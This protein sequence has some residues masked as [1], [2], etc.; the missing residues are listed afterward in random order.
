[1]ETFC[2]DCRF[3]NTTEC[4]IKLMCNTFWPAKSSNLQGWF[5]SLLAS[6]MKQW[7]MLRVPEE[8]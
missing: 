8:R 1:M 5:E 3:V 6:V 7:V 4:G 2:R